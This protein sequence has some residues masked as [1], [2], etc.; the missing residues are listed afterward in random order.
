M[1]G[2]KKLLPVSIVALM[3]TGCGASFDV[4]PSTLENYASSNSGIYSDVTSD[5]SSYDY[6][7]GVYVTETD[8]A[9]VEMW[10]FDT[11]INASAWFSENVED[12]KSGS[13]SISGSNTTTSGDYTI[14]TS[15]TC[16]RVLFCND[17][18]IYAYGDDKDA[19]N[20]VLSSMNITK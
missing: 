1:K 11:K 15:E 16:Y 12:L 14:N 2:L 9:H 8:D 4:T 20:S 3:L 19:V 7:E 6:V 17:K 10:D 18:G 5:Y 13:S